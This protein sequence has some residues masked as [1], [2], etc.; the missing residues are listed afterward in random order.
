M[1]LRDSFH[2]LK[3]KDFQIGLRSKIHAD[4]NANV[5]DTLK[6]NDLFLNPKKKKKL[7]ACFPYDQEMVLLRFYPGKMK[8]YV[9]IK[10]VHPCL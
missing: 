8:I 10:P 9:P 1:I 6:E 7:N 3:E 4:R 2:I 5:I